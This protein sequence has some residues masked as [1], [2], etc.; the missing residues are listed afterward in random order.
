MR[1]KI[2]YHPL[3]IIALGYFI[4]SML[5]GTLALFCSPVVHIYPTRIKLLMERYNVY[6]GK[7][8][9]F[10]ILRCADVPSMIEY[11]ADVVLVS[12]SVDLDEIVC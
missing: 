12:S 10:T 2:S 3:L 7:L 8:M 1:L 4:I 6:P 11:R 5:R 9:M